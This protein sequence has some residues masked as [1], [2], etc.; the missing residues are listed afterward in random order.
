MSFF[1]SDK[2][3]TAISKW[4]RAGTKA[5]KV[6]F[7]CMACNLSY[8]WKVSKAENFLLVA[9]SST[10]RPQNLLLD[11]DHDSER[12]LTELLLSLSTLFFFGGL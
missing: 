6:I 8:F 1:D 9:S 11:Q 3:D 12:I 2:S 4:A 10:F 5:A 7:L